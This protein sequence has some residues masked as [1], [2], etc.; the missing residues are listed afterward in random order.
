MIDPSKIE[1][2]ILP[3]YPGEP[4]RPAG[5]SHLDFLRPA[6]PRQACVATSPRCTSDGTKATHVEPV[7]TIPAQSSGHTCT[8]QLHLESGPATLD[9]EIAV[10][11]TSLPGVAWWQVNA[12]VETKNGTFLDELA[13]PD[14]TAPSRPRKYR[15]THRHHQRLT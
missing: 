10:R 3:R 15:P 5:T 14:P 1:P 4:S 7:G 8:I 13:D 2:A 11:S 6:G 12:P 9:F